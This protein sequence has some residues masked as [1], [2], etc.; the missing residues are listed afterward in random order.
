MTVQAFIAR[1][2]TWPL[3]RRT[4]PLILV[5]VEEGVKS[6]VIPR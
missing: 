5:V 3:H 4:V 1:T 6:F 2:R